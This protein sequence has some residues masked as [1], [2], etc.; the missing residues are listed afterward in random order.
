LA[1]DALIWLCSILFCTLQSVSGIL[2]LT[3]WWLCNHIKLFILNLSCTAWANWPTLHEGKFVRL[4]LTKFSA[5]PNISNHYKII[6]LYKLV[7][8]HCG[9]GNTLSATWI[10]GL[11]PLC[12]TAVWQ[13]SSQGHWNCNR[14]IINSFTL[15][16]MGALSQASY[17]LVIQFCGVHWILSWKC[18]STVWII[19]YR[20]FWVITFPLTCRQKQSQL[21][22]I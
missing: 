4:D 21:L 15:W 17:N 6:E 18:M 14:S 2:E 3:F 7:D 22:F 5:Q 1:T 11:T 8:W 20:I 16:Q 12:L 19:G 9:H 13:M 10:H